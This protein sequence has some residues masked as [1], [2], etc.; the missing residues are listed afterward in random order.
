MD[1]FSKALS[2]VL[3]RYQDRGIEVIDIKDIWIDTSIPE[4]LM[5]ELLR[6]GKVEVPD[7]IME[8]KKGSHAVW[9]RRKEA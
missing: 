2:N 8:I 3:K 9:R 6:S 1:S 5:V 4:D 7:G